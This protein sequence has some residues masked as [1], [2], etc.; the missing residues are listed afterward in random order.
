MNKSPI[1]TPL[2]S[3]TLIL[4]T[5]NSL[6]KIIQAIFLTEAMSLKKKS[7]AYMLLIYRRHNGYFSCLSFCKKHVT[8]SY[9]PRQIIE[10][11]FH[12]LLETFTIELAS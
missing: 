11:Y 12:V 6:Y 5:G 2:P 9:P 10:E 3:K 8:D 4:I 7:E 1:Y